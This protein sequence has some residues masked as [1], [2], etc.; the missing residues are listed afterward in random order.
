M[1]R[2]LLSI[3]CLSA[4]AF[5]VLAQEAKPSPTPAAAEKA[6]HVLGVGSPA[7]EFKLGKF[8]K[9]EAVAALDPK[10]TY[11]VECWATWC[12]PCVRAFPHLTQVAKDTA[13]K[14]TVIGVNVWE[15]ASADQVQ[16]FVDKQGDRM[17]Y[18]VAADAGNGVATGWLAAAGQN[19]IPCAFVVVKGKIAW[20]GHPSELGGEMVL[21][22]AAGKEI[23]QESPRQAKRP[24]RSGA[25][26][27]REYSDQAIEGDAGAMHSTGYILATGLDGVAKDPVMAHAWFRQGAQFSTD[28]KFQAVEKGWCEALAKKMTPEQL[29]RAK[30][31]A[32]RLNREILKR[33]AGK[34]VEG[35]RK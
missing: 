12:G 31:E 24:K 17:G 26:E 33:K 1:T 21:D 4:C 5:G 23:K 11:V 15:Q 22:L 7:P 16:A 10:E 34:R 30:V 18:R 19:G 8:Y 14:A 25:E 3:L 28:A 29:E 13:G 6:K 27:L 20:I 9:G 2:T 32:E 35:G